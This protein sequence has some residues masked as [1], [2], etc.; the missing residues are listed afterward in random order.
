MA[1]PA[2]TV[3][4][5]SS[6][7]QSTLSLHPS[8]QWLQSFLSTQK[9]NIPLSSLLA[10]ARIRLLNSDLTSSLST[11]SS[12]SSSSSST[13]PA[14]NM[15]FPSDIHNADVKERRLPGP[16]ALQILGVEDLTRSRWEQIEAIEAAERGEGTKGREVVRVVPEADGGGGGGGGG[17]A[18][19]PAPRGGPS[20]RG[21]GSCKV[22]MQDARGIM[23]FGIELKPVKGLSGG[24]SIGTKV[25]LRNVLVARGVLLLEPNTTTLL[26]GRIEASHKAWIDNRKAELRAG[27]GGMEGTRR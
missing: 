8:S 6:H 14:G 15:T 12:T 10:T 18:G 26:G 22:L 27:I 20:E 5:I 9:S 25:V 17:R 11:N 7:L 21:S 24:M 1:F 4:Q 3:S 23:A 19:G 2:N 13:S 16:I